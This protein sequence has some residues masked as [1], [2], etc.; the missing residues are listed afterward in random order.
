MR[1]KSIIWLSLVAVLLTSTMVGIAPAPATTRMYVD[2]S[3]IVDPTKVVGSV[4]AILASFALGYVLAGAAL[5]GCVGC[6]ST[7]PAAQMTGPTWH[8]IGNTAVSRVEGESRFARAQALARGALD[9][10]KPGGRLVIPVGGRFD[11]QQLLLISKDQEG[12][13]QRRNIEPVRFVPLTG[14]H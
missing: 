13:F 6:H 9:Q 1:G 14:S 7:D 8:N 3:A 10:L 5:G 2:P 12:A 4:F 11:V